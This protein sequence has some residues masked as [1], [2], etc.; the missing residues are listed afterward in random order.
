[1]TSAAH[2]ELA[3]IDDAPNDAGQDQ[4]ADDALTVE[5]SVIA[6]ARGP[7]QIMT[8]PDGTIVAAQTHVTTIAPPDGALAGQDATA[9]IAEMLTQIVPLAGGRPTTGEAPAEAPEIV[10]DRLVRS[11]QRII[12]LVN[13]G[14]VNQ[15]EAK[16]AAAPRADDP[17]AAAAGRLSRINPSA[18]GLAGGPVIEHEPLGLHGRFTAQFQQSRFDRTAHVRSSADLVR[19]GFSPVGPDGDSRSLLHRIAGIAGLCESYPAAC[20]AL[21][22]WGLATMAD[23]SLPGLHLSSPALADTMAGAAVGD[24][25]WGDRP[26]VQQGA[27][28]N[29]A[30]GDPMMQQS[31]ASLSYADSIFDGPAAAAVAADTGYDSPSSHGAS[32]SAQPPATTFDGEAPGHGAAQAD[33]AFAE[34]APQ[35]GS[36]AEHSGAQLADFSAALSPD[37]AGSSSDFGATGFGSDNSDAAVS[38][39]GVSATG[40]AWSPLSDGGVTSAIGDLTSALAGDVHAVSSAVTSLLGDGAGG[41]VGDLTTAV[42][43]DVSAVGDAVSSLLGDGGVGGAV[44]DLTAAVAGDVSAVGDAVSSLLGDGGAVGGLTTAVAGDVSAVGDV[45]TVLLGDGGVAGAVGD[46]GTAVA[47]TTGAV[48]NALPAILTDSPIVLDASV[49]DLGNGVG[50]VAAALLGTSS[51]TGNNGNH[52]GSTLSD[53]ADALGVNGASAVAATLTGADSSTGIGNGNS[54]GDALTGVLDTTVDTLAATIGNGNASATGNGNANSNAAGAG[55]VAASS[56]G[57]GAVDTLVH[58]LANGLLT[59]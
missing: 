52:L 35:A 16:S 34:I 22:L 2:L 3:E 17:S 46:L 13:Q 30:S 40:L 25:D 32:A 39:G 44:G 55:D 31:D 57:G 21:G 19:V 41:A 51:D 33:S 45:I 54:S 26:V 6:T 27:D 11:V 9:R 29:P 47:G 7:L 28:V 18:G 5:H 20:H 37:S 49:A 10:D 56:G 48:A 43:G 50:E 53:T 8:L 24:G 12:D 36:G 14:G 23:I 42:A 58:G 1:M 4:P 38:G 15:G 59:G